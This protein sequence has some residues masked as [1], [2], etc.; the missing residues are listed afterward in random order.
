[1]PVISQKDRP[2]GLVLLDLMVPVPVPYLFYP[3]PEDLTYTYPSRGTIIQTLDGGWVD[4]WGE[5]LTDIV[6]KGTT[7]WNG[8]QLPGELKYY[9]LRDLVMLEYHE[10]RAAHAKA[11]IPIDYVKLYWVDTLNLTVYEV[12]PVS[13]VGNR[14][15]QRPL[16][17]QFTL[18]LAGLRRNFGLSDLISDGLGSLLGGFGGILPGIL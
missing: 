5:G 18:R 10:L 12:Y 8:E 15:R 3:R 17:Y 6:A 11:G 14:N 1:M 7:G 16:L 13:F 4:D 9:A 2:V